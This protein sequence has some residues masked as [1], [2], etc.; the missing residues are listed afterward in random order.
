MTSFLSQLMTEKHS[1]HLYL[2]RFCGV[3]K[4]GCNRSSDNSFNQVFEGSFE[5]QLSVSPV[6]KCD[7]GVMAEL[8]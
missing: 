2:A 8:L 3:F 5:H 7:Q 6:S 1:C 4:K